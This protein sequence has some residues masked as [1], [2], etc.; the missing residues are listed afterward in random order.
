MRRITPEEVKAAYDKTGLKPD[1]GAYRRYD[2]SP[3]QRPFAACGLGVVATAEQGEKWWDWIESH[4]GNYGTEA[5]SYHYG[6]VAG[7]DGQ[8]QSRLGY[9]VDA[10]DLGYLDGKAAAAAVLQ[11]T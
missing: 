7:F 3:E 10:Y 2:E 9:D 4:S 8:R 6:F 5:N 11:E 1:R